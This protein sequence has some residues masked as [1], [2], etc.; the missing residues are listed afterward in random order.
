[1]AYL[2]Q[3]KKNDIGLN[4][5]ERQS[6]ASYY[7]FETYLVFLLYTYSITIFKNELN[8]F[9]DFVHITHRSLMFVLT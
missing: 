9:D 7:P 4:V 1:M 3:R 8:M 6:N 2:G 5:V